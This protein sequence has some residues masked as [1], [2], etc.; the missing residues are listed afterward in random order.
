M[1][2]FS[3]CFGIGQ[4]VGS[5]DTGCTGPDALSGLGLSCLYIGGGNAITTPPSLNPDGSKLEL[6]AVCCANDPATTHLV[7]TGTNPTTCTKGAGPGTHCTNPPNAANIRACS[8]D[9]DCLYSCV[10]GH[11]A[12]NS[13]C[14]TDQDCNRCVNSHCSYNPSQTCQNNMD[15]P[16][17][18]APAAACA[19][20]AN[21]FFG[22][23]LPIASGALSVCVVNV[24]QQDAFGQLTTSDGNATITYPLSSR[25]YLTGNSTEPCPKCVNNVCDSGRN[26]GMACTPVGSEQTTLDCPP[27]LSTWVGPIPV[28]LSNVTTGQSIA[29]ADANGVFCASDGQIQSGAF[30][31]VFARYILE[32]G[33]PA[34]PLTDTAPHAS[35]LASTFCIP[36]SGS[37]AVDGAGGLPGPGATSLP[38]MI[39]LVP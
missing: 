22:P 31:N 26:Q 38:G 8:S 2:P 33:S 3:G 16:G 21:C 37:P 23:P 9:G 6:D 27:T 24:I 10:N 20:D 14:T 36:A 39:Q 28:S 11:C 13:V 32:K 4:N 29:T 15:C 19:L 30:G 34:G 35:T 18:P 1:A 25:V 5:P 12:D 17:P 7:A